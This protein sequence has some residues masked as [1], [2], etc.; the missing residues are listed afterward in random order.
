MKSIVFALFL[1]LSFQTKAQSNLK[2]STLKKDTI[3]K[4]DSTQKR[5]R[6]VVRI[7]VEIVDGDTM[8]VYLINQF[9]KSKETIT[10]EEKDNY[11]K[12]VRYV[13]KALPYAKLAAFR[14]QMME[15]NLNLLT[16]EKARKKYIKES[17]KAVKKQFMDDLKNFYVEE[18]KILLKLIHRETG[19]TT[20]DILKNYRGTFETLFWQAMAKTYDANMKVTYDPVI[21][22]QIEEII[23]SLEVDN[24]PKN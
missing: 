23:K 9:V 16:T 19:K 15:D 8:S 10:Q 6:Y 2:D 22:Y 14:L 13:K 17:E 20:W 24:V 12:L 1:L 5:D 21:D 7:G 4:Q 18:G 3:Q 11:A